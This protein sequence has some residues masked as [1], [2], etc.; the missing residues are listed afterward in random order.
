VDDVLVRTRPVVYPE[1]QQVLRSGLFSETVPA[2]ADPT[3]SPG[4]S[5]PGETPCYA[6]RV[7]PQA[8]EVVADE[9]QQHA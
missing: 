9:I 2:T 3:S 4:G 6:G 8:R 1:I 7:N 5:S